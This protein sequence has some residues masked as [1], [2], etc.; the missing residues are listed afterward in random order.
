M[1]SDAAIPLSWFQYDLPDALI[2]QAPAE[3]A[4]SSRLMRV[5]RGTGEVEHRAFLDLPRLL[6]PGDLIVV[7]RTRVIPARV[8]AIR[9]TGGKVELLFHR[10]LDGSVLDASAWSVM[11]RPGKALKP[12]ATVSV[13]DWE[14]EVTEREGMFAH[15]RAQGPLWP[16]LEERGELPLP[17]YINRP[18]GPV[19]S[20][21]TQYQ[22]LF[23]RELGAVAAPTASLHFTPR[24][25]DALAERGVETAELVLHVGPGTFLP[26]RPENASDVREHQMHTESFVIP[27]PT[28]TAIERTKTR[29][30]RVIAIGTTAARA[31]ETWGKTGRQSGESDLFVYPGYSFSVV[32]GMV[33]NFHLPGSTLL[34]LVS[35]MAGLDPIRRAYAMAIEE[36]YRFFSYGDAML[37]L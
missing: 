29:G 22:S 26:V 28:L 36:H 21:E 13:G 5:D 35:A 12:G 19:E 1:A 14:L 7:N 24:V 4:D 25:V 30:G 15:I 17:P 16:L 23:A 10:P 9:P 8:R 31:L 33:T 18:E 11:G 32:D 34:M 3:P 27:E 37:I 2:A 6:E 20:D